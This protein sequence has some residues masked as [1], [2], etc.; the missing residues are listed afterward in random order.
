MKVKSALLDQV[1]GIHYGFGTRDEPK[2]SEFLPSWDDL[3]PEK[4]QVHGIACGEV[5]G[6]AQDLGEVDAL[7]TRTPGIPISVVTAD[8]VPVLLSRKDGKAVAAIHAGW[9]GTAAR[10]VRATWDKL[11]AQGEKPADWVAAVGPAIGPCC[12]EV[13]EEMAKDFL[14]VF[15]WVGGAVPS[16][17]HLDLPQINTQELKKL[18]IGGVDLIRACTR[19]SRNP[20]FFSYRKDGSGSRQWSVIR[21][22]S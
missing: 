12:Y 2:P 9:R 5:T 20:K 16:F 3:A 1:R 8:C 13:S 4:K 18:G 19:C 7:F 17:R 21:I 14:R 15:G 10:I 22:N 11:R 6:P